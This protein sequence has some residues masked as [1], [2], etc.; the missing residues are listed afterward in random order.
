MSLLPSNSSLT[1]Q[2]FA[3]FLDDRT[4]EN[5]TVLKID[6]LSCDARLLSHLAVSVNVDISN[7]EEKEARLYIKNAIEIKRYAGTVWAVE[8]AINAT[9]EDATLKEWFDA[10]LEQGY[11]DV[12]V[13][14]PADPNAIYS[15]KTWSRA[16]KLIHISK[17]VRS[18]LHHFKLI[19]P[20]AVGKIETT[21][22][23]N[24]K[25]DAQN[26]T[27]QTLNADATVQTQ[28]GSTLK[29]D[30]L[31][32]NT[33]QNLSAKADVKATTGAFLEFDYSKNS[34]KQSLSA[35]ATIRAFTGNSFEFDYSRNQ[36]T[37]K[38]Q[39]K[40]D[41]ASFSGSSLEFD[42]SKNS[43]KRDLSAK[44]NLQIITTALFLIEL[45]KSTSLNHNSD[46]TLQLKGG[47]SWQI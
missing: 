3:E 26:T 11:F 45:S 36:T 38:L 29:F 41:I 24:F 17:N 16:K 19:F 47:V 30:Y 44:A 7:L 40:S 6:P 23:L 4:K 46:A 43:T 20:N 31:R 22:A 1:E 15:K 12:E 25:L 5:Y 2:K 10:D 28:A 8:K 37:T 32:N 27:E 42:Y 33:K 34:T 21:N 13:K 9:F 39:A 18:H 14:L 35:N